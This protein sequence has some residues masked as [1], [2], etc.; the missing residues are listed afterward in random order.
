MRN[1]MFLKKKKKK[2]RAIF[3]VL[4]YSILQL[5]QHFA[6]IKNPERL[7]VKEPPRHQCE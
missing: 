7:A 2:K 1:Y 6:R 3:H 4:L 5:L